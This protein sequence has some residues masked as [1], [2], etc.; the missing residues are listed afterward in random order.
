M[1][2]LSRLLVKQTQIVYCR[3]WFKLTNMPNYL[4]Y[5]L[6]LCVVSKVTVSLKLIYSTCW[7]AWTKSTARPS[8]PSLSRVTTGKSR[9]CFYGRCCSCTCRREAART[10][11]TRDPFIPLPHATCNQRCRKLP[12]SRPVRVRCCRITPPDPDAQTQSTDP[13]SRPTWLALQLVGPWGP[14]APVLKGPLLLLVPTRPDQ[15]THQLNRRQ[16]ILYH[17]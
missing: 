10:S 11:A 17:L 7:L 3:W 15:S 12:P 5:I 16:F 13:A 6:V 2:Q 1:Y 9:V 8:P 4:P 14:R